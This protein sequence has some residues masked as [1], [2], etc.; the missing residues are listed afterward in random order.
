VLEPEIRTFVETVRAAP[1]LQW[2]QV[3][4]AGMDRPF[5]G[6]LRAISAHSAGNST[7]HQRNVI[8]QF[9]ANLLHF[10]RSEPLVNEWQ[11]DA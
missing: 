8:A 1:H 9:K 10:L 4:S 3:P 7:G 2:L 6:E 11:P 5:Y